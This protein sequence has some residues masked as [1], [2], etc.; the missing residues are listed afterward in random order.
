MQTKKRGDFLYSRC[1]ISAQR[2]CSVIPNHIMAWF[3][4]HLA[5]RSALDDD[6]SLLRVGAD[7]DVRVERA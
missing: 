3:A 4:K 2:F 6:P 5:L 1:A 7:G